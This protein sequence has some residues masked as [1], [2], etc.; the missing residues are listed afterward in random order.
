MPSDFDPTDFMFAL[1]EDGIFDLV[2]QDNTVQT[3]KSFDTAIQMIIFCERRADPSEVPLPQYRRGWWGNTVLSDT[4]F[5]IG[6]KF[7]LLFQERCT[8]EI[9]NKGIDY[10]RQASQW[11]VDDGFL[12][13]IEVS[14]KFVGIDGI[15]IFIK[16]NTLDGKVDSR[17]YTLWKNTGKPPIIKGVPDIPNLLYT[18]SGI[19]AG[20]LVTEDDANIN[21]QK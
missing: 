13:S 1:D 12:K 18:R 21:L 11:L 4:G 9:L 7:W 8:Q 10:L 6:S 20:H 14:G 5:E 15:E 2:I 16:Y 17:Y 3:V 19:V